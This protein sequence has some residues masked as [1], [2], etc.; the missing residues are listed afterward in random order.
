VII[1][2]HSARLMISATCY[3]CFDM[4]LPRGMSALLREWF[5]LDTK[6]TRLVGHRG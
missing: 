5:S 4:V 6:V 3:L 2:P 1:S